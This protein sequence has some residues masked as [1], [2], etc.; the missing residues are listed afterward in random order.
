MATNDLPELTGSEKQVAWAET[1]R[2]S[3]ITDYDAHA[4]ARLERLQKDRPNRQDRLAEMQ[5]I[6]DEV[7]AW[8]VSKTDAAWWIKVFRGVGDKNVYYT[9]AYFSSEHVDDVRSINWENYF[10]W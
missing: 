10:D 1:L 8:L 4:T 3:A 6:Y 7:R 9:G 5:A 2:S